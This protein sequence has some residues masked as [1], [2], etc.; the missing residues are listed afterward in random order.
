LAPYGGFKGGGAAR[1]SRRL[2]FGG[3][4]GEGGSATGWGAAAASRG[5]VPARAAR[6]R[7]P[8]SDPTPKFPADPGVTLPRDP[9]PNTQRPTPNAQTPNAQEKTSE[10]RLT[11]Y[12]RV[13]ELDATIIIM[14]YNFRPR[15]LAAAL[16]RSEH[17]TPKDRS[18]TQRPNTQRPRIN[19]G[20]PTNL[21]YESCR[22]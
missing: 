16:S 19:V 20:I 15:R 17:P 1:L 12:T 4:G 13:V 3:G 9:T 18:N 14:Y 7:R 21:L 2:G 6:N 22:A 10:Y 11:Y 8:G 5:G